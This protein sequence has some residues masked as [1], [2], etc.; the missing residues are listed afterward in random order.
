M[1]DTVGKPSDT[2]VFP[3]LE[4]DR[5]I[6]DLIPFMPTPPRWPAFNSVRHLNTAW[7]IRELD[8]QMAIFRSLTAEEEAATGLFLSLK[9]R[10]YEGANKLNQRN[11]IHKNAVIPLFDAITRVLAKVGSQMPPSQLYLDSKENP[12]QLRSRFE[13]KHP[14][15]GKTVWAAPQP[16]LHFSVSS[17]KTGEEMKKEDFSAGIDEIVSETN[18]K[19]IID[20]IR[21]RANLRNQ[22]L[23][24]ATDG[25]P[26]INGDIEPML[27]RYQK[28][29]FIILRMFM[30]IDPYPQQ[31]LFVQ[32][33]L[34][35]F[36]RT[37]NLLPNDFEF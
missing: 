12:V 25:Y 3:I 10:G 19:N 14:Q 22:L 11:H 2:I 23:Y 13:H 35:A 27:K 29:V 32:Q 30:M 7:K 1:A 4:L 26:S 17:L 18:V 31:Q 34:H 15:T 21:N 28:N 16:P 24:A 6:V 8:P 36:M 37:L 5:G 9:R 33:A 20:Y